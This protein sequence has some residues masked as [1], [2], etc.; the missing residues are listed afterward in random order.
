MKINK[1]NAAG[2]YDYVITTSKEKQFQRSS[3]MNVME[4]NITFFTHTA[5]SS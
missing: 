4:Q 2:K 3:Q 5:T 1:T